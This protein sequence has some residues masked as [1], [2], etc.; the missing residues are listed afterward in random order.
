[1]EEWNSR[2]EEE[3]K[4]IQAH[5]KMLAPKLKEKALKEEKQQQDELLK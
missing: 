1:M 3:Q 5:C 2:L 4:E